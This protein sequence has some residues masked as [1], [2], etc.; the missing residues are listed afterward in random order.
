MNLADGNRRRGRVSGDRFGQK[1]AVPGHRFPIVAGSKPKVQ[2]ARSALSAPNPAKPAFARAETVPEP[3]DSLPAGNRQPLDAVR[4]H[5]RN[6]LGLRQLF[7]CRALK[8]HATGDTR[9]LAT[10]V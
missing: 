8:A 2:L 4:G 9:S 5:A 3:V 7:R 10:E 1:P 6:W